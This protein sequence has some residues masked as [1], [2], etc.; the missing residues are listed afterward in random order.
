MSKEILLGFLEDA[1]NDYRNASAVTAIINQLVSIVEEHYNKPI[2]TQVTMQCPPAI[3]QLANEMES[4][5][6]QDMKDKITQLEIHVFSEQSKNQELRKQKAKITEMFE[7]TREENKKRQQKL[8]IASN[9]YYS[10]IE[11][12]IKQRDKLKNRLEQARRNCDYFVSLHSEISVRYEEVCKKNENLLNMLAEQKEEIDKLKNQI[13]ELKTEKQVILVENQRVDKLNRDLQKEKFDLQEQ[14]NNVSE[15]FDLANKKQKEL[16]IKLN[17][18]NQD[19]V[20][21][22][23]SLNHLKET[24]NGQDAQ[25]NLL[26]QG[27]NEVAE[28]R[29]KLQEQK[30]VLQEFLNRMTDKYDNLRKECLG[31]Q[32]TIN[33]LLGRI[34]FDGTN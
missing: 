17:V 11:D 3:V 2:P 7:T 14:R 20:Q 22:Q 13:K 18:V 26:Q 4:Q 24:R 9:D 15:M 27:Y 25:Y 23:R 28:E 5:I 21:L 6:P 1:K 31:L 30:E 10:S 8:Q 12:V 32:K 19:Y 29:D 34:P 16:Q 33:D